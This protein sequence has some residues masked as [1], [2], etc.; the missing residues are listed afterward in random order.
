MQL[1]TFIFIGRSGC[2]KGTQA[3]LLDVEIR[4]ND[5]EQRPMLY[6]ETGAG[7]RKFLATESHTVEKAK[8]RAAKGQRQ[9]D[10][11]AIWMW[12]HVFVEEYTGNEHLLIDGTPRSLT[13]AAALH[14]A[15]TFYER[16]KPTVVHLNVSRDWSFKHLK[17]R[18]RADD[19][20]FDI[21]ERLNWFDRDV[22]PAIYFF[23][24]HP[25]YNFIEING[26]KSIEDVHKELISKV[27]IGQ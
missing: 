6:I 12:S 8:T 19:S 11:L 5:S 23:R 14:T 21:N 15:L 24:T 2:G 7:F 3:R 10:F 9:P 26:E 22:N 13:D 17:A 27:D 4:K 20:D 18:G 1:Q 25:D 16:P